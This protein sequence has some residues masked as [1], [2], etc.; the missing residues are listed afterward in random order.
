M[1]FN[2]HHPDW[3]RQQGNTERTVHFKSLVCCQVS[4]PGF[5]TLAFCSACKHGTRKWALSYSIRQNYNG[6][7]LPHWRIDS[8]ARARG[9]N[10]HNELQDIDDLRTIL[11][12]QCE[13]NQN[14]FEQ[15]ISGHSKQLRSQQT[16]VTAN[17]F[18]THRC[19]SWRY[20]QYKEPWPVY[21]PTAIATKREEE[22]PCD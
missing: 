13:G 20:L 18:G 14:F 4:R 15:G 6:G 9:W 16:L 7:P 19:P 12:Q 17:S 22:H 11:L 5:G 2:R 10:D 3:K 8:W 1:H 21:F